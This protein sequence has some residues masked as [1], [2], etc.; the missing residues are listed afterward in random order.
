MTGPGVL[1]VIDQLLQLG[2]AER[3]LMRMIRKLPESGYRPYLLTFRLN[4]QVAAFRDI[5]CPVEVYPVHNLYGPNAF[6]Y[7]PRLIRRIRS[8]GI[9]VVHTFFETSDLWAGPLAKAAG[10]ALI[11]SRRDAGLQ[12]NWRLNLLYRGAGRIFDQVHAVS[13]QVRDYVIQC[14][15]MDP[16]RVLCVPNG[17]ELDAAARRP[18][19]HWGLPEGRP[20]IVT[21]ANIRRVKGIDVLART[22]AAV[23]RRRPDALFVVAGRVISAEYQ[24]EVERLAA[25]LGVTA[26]LRFLGETAEPLGLL[27][28]ADIFCLPSRTEGMSNALL[29]AMAS[30]LP[31]VATGVGGNCQL[32]EDGETGFLTPVEAAEAAAE[33]IL[34]LLEHP[35]R[36]RAMGEKARRVVEERYSAA[37]MMRTLAEQYDALLERPA[38]R[39]QA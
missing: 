1:Y 7:A 37:T 23:C 31:A 26:N 34:W 25:E 36:A 20:L 14:D 18:R 5:P 39:Q 38:A 4:P 9:R 17:L 19:A 10:A 3:I 11:S 21:L 30:A 29:E 2:G 35:D 32:V 16:A 27:A 6:R 8:E 28:A 22:A 12:R 13:E 15:R 24:A 33:R